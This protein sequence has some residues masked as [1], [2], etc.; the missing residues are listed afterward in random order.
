MPRGTG[1]GRRLGRDLKKQEAGF[2]RGTTPSGWMGSPWKVLHTDSSGCPAE[3]SGGSSSPSDTP[4]LQLCSHHRPV[5]LRVSLG[6]DVV[7]T[8]AGSAGREQQHSPQ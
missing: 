1:W 5:Q 6:W 7:P 2:A 8:S 3:A 4:Q